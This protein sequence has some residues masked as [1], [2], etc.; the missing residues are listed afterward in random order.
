MLHGR[1]AADAAAATAQTTFAQGGS[2]SDLP[3][4]SVGKDGISI[5]EANT[6]LGFAASNK[7]V[8]RKIDEGAI[9]VNDTKVTDYAHVVKPGD[10]VSFGQKKHGLI[11]ADAS[12]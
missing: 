4:L 5:L 9:R 2:G 10:K 6:A 1:E 8:K 12:A 7:E 3:A 11:V